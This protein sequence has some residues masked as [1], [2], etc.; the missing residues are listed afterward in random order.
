MV[1]GEAQPLRTAFSSA[2]A[3]RRSLYVSG[4]HAIPTPV[5]VIKGAYWSM[6]NPTGVQKVAPAERLPPAVEGPI[7]C[8]F[9][10]EPSQSPEPRPRRGLL[11]EATEEEVHQV[12]PDPRPPQSPAPNT[13]SRALT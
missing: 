4:D 2:I 10:K 9:T 11:A 7:G 1:D 3:S 6:V 12:T 8:P 5:V 13:V